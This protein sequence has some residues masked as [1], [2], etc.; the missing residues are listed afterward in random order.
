M[1]AHPSWLTWIRGNLGA[2]RSGRWVRAPHWLPHPS[3]AGFKRLD[4]AEPNGQVADYALSLRDGSRIHA[5]EHDDGSLVVHRDKWDPDRSLLHAVVHFFGET[6][7][8]IGTLVVG[9]VLGTVYVV[10]QAAGGNTR[11]RRR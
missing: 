7:L 11:R 1:N 6:K 8:G 4:I 9:G 10:A 5:H 2:L 3:Q